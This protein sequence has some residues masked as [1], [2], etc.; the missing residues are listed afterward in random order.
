MLLQS[1][2]DS[3][4]W[5]LNQNVFFEICWTFFCPDIDL[6]A[7]RIN[8]QLENYISWLPDPN[9]LTSDAFSIDWSKFKPYI[10]PPFS[11]VGRILQ[12]LDEDEVSKAIL[13]IPKW[14]TQPW[15]PRLLNML[16]G[17]PVRLPIIPNLLRL[18][19]NNQLHPLNKRKMFLF[20]CIVSGKNSEAQVFQRSLS[21]SLQIHGDQVPIR[22]T[23]LYGQSG[24]F[25]VINGISIPCNQLLIN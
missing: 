11:L 20:A 25:G 18:V 24:N 1:F 6:F 2:S 15:Y 22:N 19:H 21:D 3:T 23:T 8:K 17:I 14:A 13:I 4:E 12:K 16:I 10:F 5:K 9:A 7:S